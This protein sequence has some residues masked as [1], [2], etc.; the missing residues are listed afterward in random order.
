MYPKELEDIVSSC[1]FLSQGSQSVCYKKDSS[2]VIK[3][4]QR[5][6]DVLF[7]NFTE[8]IT[9]YKDIGLPLLYPDPINVLYIDDQWCCYQQPLCRKLH[10]AD[11]NPFSLSFIIDFLEQ[12]VINDL[13]F[14]DIYITNFGY[15]HGQIKY[16]DYHNV[17]GFHDHTSNHFL[18][19]NLYSNFYYYFCKSSI[20]LILPVRWQN[21]VA[22]DYGRDIFPRPVY[23]LLSSLGSKVPNYLETVKTNLIECKRLFTE[24]RNRYHCVLYD[25]YTITFDNPDREILTKCLNTTSQLLLQVSEP[26]TEMSWIH[27]IGIAQNNRDMIV[28][29]LVPKTGTSQIHFSLENYYSIQD[30]PK[31]FFYDTILLT[32]TR[33]DTWYSRFRTLLQFSHNY[34]IHFH[35]LIVLPSDVQTC[36]SIVKNLARIIRINRI[37]KKDTSLIIVGTT[38]T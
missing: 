19:T 21:V 23:K 37:L 27:G 36:Q 35:R 25:K 7:D 13:K 15:H 2:N 14:A 32:V 31:K 20:K 26:H 24:Y 28:T 9:K 11:I 30:I 8:I 6:S 17:E 16:Y 3:C 22:N 34:I 29:S 4:C 33:L 18:V 1:Q 12:M 5:R 10:L 38:S